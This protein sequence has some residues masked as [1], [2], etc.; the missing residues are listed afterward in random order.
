MGSIRIRTPAV[1]G[2]FYPGQTRELRATIQ[3]LLQVAKSV[4]DPP[5]AMV[6]PHA[7][8]TYSGYTM[9]CAYRSLPRVPNE[10]TPGRRV[11]LVGPSHR[12]HL[13]G[14]SVGPYHA[15]QTPLGMVEVDM[16]TV[17][18]LATVTDVSR[19]MAPHSLEHSLEVHL[20]FLQMVVGNFR[21][22]PIVYGEITPERLAH[23]I[24]F[25]L[26]PDDLLVVSSD[27]SHFH[28]YEEAILLD[29]E[30]H[31]AVLHL[32]S[33]AMG[34]CEACGNIGMRA[35]LDVAQ[36]RSWRVALADYRNSGDTSGDKSR[37]VGYASYLFHPAAAFCV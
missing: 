8:Y 3:Q 31:R 26:E 27:L 5:C 37:V 14:I 22:V 18:R 33:K 25:C 20:P 16:E 30:S 12:V 10:T 24:Q 28:S 19:S 2:T 34:E 9:A 7:G 13:E 23:L 17:E 32:D 6:A 36:Q 21:L 1:A 4:A 11:V 29:E 35:I 15:F